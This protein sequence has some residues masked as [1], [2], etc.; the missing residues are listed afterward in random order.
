M[1]PNRPAYPDDC[2]SEEPDFWRPDDAEEGC[3]CPL[4]LKKDF[5]DLFT[6]WNMLQ[7]NIMPYGQRGYMEQPALWVQSI[8]IINAAVARLRRDKL[9]KDKS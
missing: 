4:L 8:E 2:V 3:T 5:S 9:E 6:A 1:C 7:N